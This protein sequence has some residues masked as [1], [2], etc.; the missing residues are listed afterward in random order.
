MRGGPFDGRAV[1]TGAGKSQVGRRL[2]RS[3]LDLTV[4]ACLRAIA[5]AGLSEADVSHERTGVIAGSGG[6]STSALLAAHQS[7]L[8]TGAT[9]RIGPFAVPK[10]MCSTVSANVMCGRV[11]ATGS[12]RSSVVTGSAS[13]VIGPP[14]LRCRW[15]RG[16]WAGR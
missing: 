1:L 2:G 7:V 8:Q 13:A 9:K 12:G 5:D 6:P 15:S 16:R 11:A 4:E 10:A 14:P 3:G